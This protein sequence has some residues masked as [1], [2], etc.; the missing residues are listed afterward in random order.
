M[1]AGVRAVSA[2]GLAAV[3][4]AAGIAVAV[5][6]SLIIVALHAGASADAELIAIT[7]ALAAA[8]SGAVGG[9]TARRGG[10]PDSDPGRR[11]DGGQDQTR[12]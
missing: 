9:Y 1:G 7:G 11:G 8:A 10:G 6:G 4:L 12:M 2:A 5:A 3:I